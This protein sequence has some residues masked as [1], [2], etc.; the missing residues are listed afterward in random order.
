MKL[1]MI[2]TK[3]ICVRDTEGGLSA[4]FYGSNLHRLISVKISHKSG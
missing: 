2:S 4:I 3:F 1:N